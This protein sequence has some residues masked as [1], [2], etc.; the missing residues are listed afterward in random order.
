VGADDDRGAPDVSHRVLAVRY[1]TRQTTRA[2]GFHR[3]AASGEPDGPLGMDYFLWVLQGPEGTIVVDTG[4]DPEV[5]ARMGRTCLCP[6]GEALARLGIE[7][8]T[9]G[10]VVLTHL[11]YDHIGN[12]GLF[13]DAELVVA[14]RELDFWTGPIARRGHF[15]SHAR[16]DEVAAVARA[17]DEGRVVTV[18]EAAEVAPGVR[19]IRVGGHSPG[20]LI[21]V[22]ETGAGEVVLASD[23]V[24]YYEELDD[25]R[26]FALF[27]DLEAVYRGYDT[28][29]ELTDAG[30]ALVP[31]HDP[32]VMERFRALDGELSGLAVEV[33]PA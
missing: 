29:R 6:P 21:L 26:P 28:V 8:S 19:A 12:V 13:G 24:H 1:G 7:P 31:G 27:A 25:D 10:R 17:R 9:V 14:E 23:A 3:H 22:V 18:D 30:R 20:Q 15:A 11:H 2:D 16:A 5:G 33:A 32:L 4:F